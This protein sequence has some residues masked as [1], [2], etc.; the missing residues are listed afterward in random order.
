M[1]IV[2]GLE[3][4]A[5]LLREAALGSDPES[6][7]LALVKRV[8]T[9]AGQTLVCAESLETVAIVP[10]ESVLSAGP[11]EA[12]LILQERHDYQIC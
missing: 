2:N 6:T 5:Y 10:K 7:I 12:C 8:D 9:G 1:A 4:I 3:A 11:D